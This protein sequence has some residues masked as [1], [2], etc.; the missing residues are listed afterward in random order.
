MGVYALRGGEANGKIK[1]HNVTTGAELLFDS[2]ADPSV[3][4]LTGRGPEN[5]YSSQDNEGRDVPWD[6][7][8]KMDGKSW[9]LMTK[10]KKKKSIKGWNLIRERMTTKLKSITPQVGEQ[11]ASLLEF[12]GMDAPLL[13][14][15]RPPHTFYV[16][17]LIRQ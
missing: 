3:W 5:E 2:A 15:T 1:Y 10:K 6:E 16:G 13:S 8:A 12:K 7:H 14:I 9:E 17:T 11:Q 4:K